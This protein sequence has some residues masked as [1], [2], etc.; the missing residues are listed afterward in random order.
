MTFFRVKKNAWEKRRENG[1]NNCGRW[2]HVLCTCEC[3]GDAE[4]PFGDRQNAGVFVDVSAWRQIIDIKDTLM[5]FNDCYM[6]KMHLACSSRKITQ[7]Y[8]GDPYF[9]RNRTNEGVRK[10]LHRKTQQ[11]VYALRLQLA[12]FK[13]GLILIFVC[14]IFALE[15]DLLLELR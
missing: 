3:C 5:S 10:D 2:R 7:K 13:T 14:M 8:F 12:S 15:C 1:N 9:S 4:S 6:P 11:I